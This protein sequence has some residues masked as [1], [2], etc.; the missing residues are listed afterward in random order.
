L[1]LIAPTAEIHTDYPSFRGI[2][3]E[4]HL[5]SEHQ[6]AFYAAGTKIDQWREGESRDRINFVE[7]F[8]YL[9]LQHPG[10]VVLGLQIGGCSDLL[11]G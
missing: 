7:R 10:G 3:N 9:I 11:Q 6:A 8:P 2:E 4:E 5:V 1:P